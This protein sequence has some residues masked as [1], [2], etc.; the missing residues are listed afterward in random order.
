MASLVFGFLG[1]SWRNKKC[2][3]CAACAQFA[4][5]VFSRSLRQDNT[6]V[7]HHQPKMPEE[8]EQARA[9]LAACPVAAIRTETNAQRSHRG[10]VERFTSTEEELSK[11]LAINPKFNGRPPPFPLRVSEAIEGVYYVGHH[12]EQTFGAVPY[13]LETKE[14]GWILVDT[15][16][17]SKSGNV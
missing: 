7:V 9:A 1:F 2:I 11:Q 13:L 10:E 3:N 6:H 8:I 5:S 4:P 15:P 16:K 12:S 14:N 17:Y